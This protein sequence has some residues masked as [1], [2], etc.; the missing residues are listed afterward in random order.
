[1]YLI[2]S[3]PLSRKQ[4]P[5]TLPFTYSAPGQ[6]GK[7]LSVPRVLNHIDKVLTDKI[8]RLFIPTMNCFFREV[9]SSE[10]P[11]TLSKSPPKTACL[12]E[13]IY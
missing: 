7:E 11:N 9:K 8:K 5:V 13:I 4:H 6:A 12:C 3:R 2:I 10:I 1:L